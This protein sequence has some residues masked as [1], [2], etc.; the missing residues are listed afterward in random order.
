LKFRMNPVYKK[1]L[2]I[3]VRTVRMAMIIL[4]YNAVLALIGLLSFYFTFNYSFNNNIDYSGILQIYLIL[5]VIEFGLVLFVVP[6][7]TASAISGEREKQTLEILLTTK[8]KPSQIIF[9]KLLSSISST[10][11]LVFSSLPILAIVFSIGGIRLFD[12]IQLMLFCVT[13]AIFVGSIG[14]FFSTC[15]KKTVP[16]TVFTYGSI[17]LL[18]IGTLAIIAVS[19]MI[20]VR[21][22]DNLYSASSTMIEYNPPGVGHA[23]N[24]LLINPAVSLLALLSKQFGSPSYLSSLLSHYGKTNTVIFDHWYAISILIQML[25]AVVLLCISVRTLDPLKNKK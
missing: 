23:I 14:I 15:F 1:E 22:Y 3:S 19:Y 6:A 18:V 12:L 21:N 13:T 9:G 25:L 24:L 8:L 4:G 20:G 2:K 16:S 5:A 17:I 7:F 11:L 10:L